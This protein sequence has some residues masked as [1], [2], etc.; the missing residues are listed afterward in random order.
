MAEV[1]AAGRPV[2]AHARGGALEIVRDGETGFLVADDDA[3]A[4]VEGMRRAETTE[5]DVGTLVASAARFSRSVFDVALRSI[6]AEAP[7]R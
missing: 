5:L 6:L 7:V 2:V 4:L 3:E 1:Q